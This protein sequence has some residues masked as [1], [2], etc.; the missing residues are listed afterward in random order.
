[1][2]QI[3]RF[4]IS[5]RLYYNMRPG[6][7]LGVVAASALVDITSSDQ[8]PFG[9][10]PATIRV[11][12]HCSALR[13]RDLTVAHEVPCSFRTRPRRILPGFAHVRRAYTVVLVRGRTI[14]SLVHCT[15]Q[16]H[17]RSITL[18]YHASRQSPMRNRC[19]KWWAYHLCRRQ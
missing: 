13:T 4:I 8:Y 15:A 3:L 5:R 9:P 7:T 18:S 10:S 2:S 14:D 16:Q 6:A 11:R 17:S 12:N 19:A 1:M